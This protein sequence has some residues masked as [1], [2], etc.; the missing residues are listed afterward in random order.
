MHQVSPDRIG[1][2]FIYLIL[3]VSF[4]AVMATCSVGAG[5]VADLQ[6]SK[7]DALAAYKKFTQDYLNDDWTALKKDLLPATLGMRY[8]TAQEINDIQY[9]KA[10]ATECRPSWW[11]Q[12][13]SSSNISFRA[14]I[15]GRSFMANYMPS[16]MLGV[17]APVGIRNGRLMVIVSWQPSLIDNPDPLPGKL[18]K[19]HH[20]TKGNMGEAIV[21][22]EL[23]HNY[24]SVN[25]P[26]GQVI[27]LYEDHLLL[28]QHLQEFYADMTSLYHGS[29]KARLAL[30][31]LRVPGMRMND[32]S[33]PHVRASLA[34]GSLIL[35][36]VLAHRDQWPSV[37]LPGKV[38]ATDVARNTIL[39]MYTHLAPQLT[40][41]EDRHLREYIGK[42]IRTRGEAVLRERGTVVLPN[43]LQFK[44]M[45]AEDR[46][47]KITRDN[48][49]KAQLKKLI[50]AGKTD[51]PDATKVSSGDK[52]GKSSGKG[53]GKKGGGIGGLI[54]H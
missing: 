45:V 31:L 41:R 24:I 6:K 27:Q 22:H 13:H 5:Q 10:A 44:L 4:F 34:I 20:L 37:H 54:G 53:S 42:F 32:S 2:K 46:Q 30:M 16:G 9:I 1:G 3:L 7:Q 39:Y 40:F 29:P 25:L 8:L 28:Y 15:W 21:W 51:K 11:P 18:A 14:T 36:N 35:W 23:G 19:V 38:P 12:T 48:W 17:Q 26:I 52:S 49:V 33:D 43:G 47:L 50:A